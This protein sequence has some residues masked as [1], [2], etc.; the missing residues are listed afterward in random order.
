MKLPLSFWLAA[1][2]LLAGAGSA[3]AATALQ[4]R[5]QLLATL[6]DSP[7]CCVIDARSRGQRLLR[8]LKDALVWKKGLRI[9]PTSAVVV[10]ADDDAKALAVGRA[11]EKSSAA[12]QVLAVKG[13]YATWHGIVAVDS[14]MPATFIIP[15]NTCESGTPIQT[16]RS[17]KPQP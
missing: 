7:P 9:A 11:I 16:L 12:P 15:K 4:D 14:G 2:F 10:V 1:V 5:E 6:K 17:G 13:G 3:T 8:P